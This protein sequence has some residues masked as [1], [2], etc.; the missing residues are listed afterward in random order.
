[1]R[2]TPAQPTNSLR[3]LARAPALKQLSRLA[4]VWG[5]GP[6]HTVGSCLQLWKGLARTAALRTGHTCQRSTHPRVAIVL[7]LDS[8]WQPRA[9]GQEK[10]E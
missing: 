4:D 6:G 1:M 3:A 10:A 9:G 2:S 8:Q 7:A 5:A